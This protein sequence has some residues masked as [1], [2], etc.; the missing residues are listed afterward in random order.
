MIYFSNKTTTDLDKIWAQNAPPLSVLD[1]SSPEAEKE[2]LPHM[3]F[4]AEEAVCLFLPLNAN[5]HDS[6][7]RWE[8]ERC[9][10]G[11]TMLIRKG[12]K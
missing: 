11:F 4:I 6:S 8:F 10:K 12:F 5:H 9:Y 2:K 3:A 7:Q 1:L